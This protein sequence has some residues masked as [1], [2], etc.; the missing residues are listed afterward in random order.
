MNTN[1]RTVR[2]AQAEL[3]SA[4]AELA[5]VGVGASASRAERAAFRVSAAEQAMEKLGHQ[6]D[7][8]A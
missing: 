5:S 1:M 4:Q 8:A 7:R 6:M 2:R 3:Q